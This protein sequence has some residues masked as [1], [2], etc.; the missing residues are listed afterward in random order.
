MRDRISK[1]KAFLVVKNYT[2]AIYELENIRRETKDSTVNRVL[3]VLLMH[4]YLEQG[5]YKKAQNFLKELHASKNQDSAMDY[6]S[7][8]GQVIS[9]AKT[10]LERYKSLGLSV[11]DRNLPVEASADVESMRLTLELIV[12]QS[13]ALSKNKEFSSNALALLEE[14]SI[15]RASLAKDPYDSKRWKDQ[16][17]DARQQI[18]G[19]GSRIINAVDSKPFEENTASSKAPSSKTIA[20][21]DLKEDNPVVPEETI[22]NKKVGD[23]IFELREPSEIPPPKPA[24]KPAG[25]EENKTGK[26]K[27][28]TLKETAV[29]DKSTEKE[30]PKEV[31]AKKEEAKSPEGP[32]RLRVAPENPKKETTPEEKTEKKA[33][34][35]KE[36]K[37]PENNVAEEEDEKVEETGPLTVGSLITYATRRVNPIYPRSARNM[38]LTGVV[39]VKVVVNEDGEVAEVED[40]EGP[41]MLRRAAG[42]AIRKWKFKP[43]MRDGQPVMATGYVNFNFSL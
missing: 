8:A 14:T 17:S 7:I 18:V 36:T 40:M 29:T 39:K 30:T 22:E 12:E 2:A 6:F 43:F 42:N 9:G 33:S 27:T 13:R 11:S 34:P 20:L 41:A 4:S 21:S 15:A 26:A 5:D 35:K 38:R 37:I 28:A 10:Q 31:V 25:K 32:I 19:S 1:A 3:I 16:I 24:N 23:N